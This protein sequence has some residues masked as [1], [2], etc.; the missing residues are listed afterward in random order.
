MD[1]GDDLRPREVE[2]VDVVLE[3]LRVIA[4]S[5]APPVLFVQPLLLQEHADGPVED[6][7]PLLEQLV[8]TL[9]SWRLG[10]GGRGHQDP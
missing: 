9:A 4:E 8:E 5:L 3:Q 7:D 10:G 1:A 6:H 2:K